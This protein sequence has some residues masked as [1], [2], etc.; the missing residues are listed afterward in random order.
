MG[1]MTIPGS[2]EIYVTYVAGV[3]LTNKEG[4]SVKFDA[5]G[6]IILCNAAGERPL[7]TLVAGGEAGSNVTIQIDG[8]TRMIAAA[9]GIIHGNAIAVDAN[10][11]AKVAAQGDYIYAQAL[12]PAFAAGQLILVDII[13]AG[14]AG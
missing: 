2:K 13:H 5:Q 9:A 8:Q 3:D 1:K 7:G 10:G 6:H 11:Q 4:L 12:E 14:I